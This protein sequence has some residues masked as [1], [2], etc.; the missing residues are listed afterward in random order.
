I[1]M[2]PHYWAGYSWLANL[3]TGQSR[4]EAAAQQAR[5]AIELAPENPRPMYQLGGALIFSGKYPEAITVLDNAI[6]IHPT[7][8]AYSNRGS[9]KLSLRRFDG[10]VEDYEQAYRLGTLDMSAVSNLAR[11]YYWAG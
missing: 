1:Q 2:R 9:A 10:A 3:Y 4:Y 7:Y 8:Q 6:A 5:K 11:A